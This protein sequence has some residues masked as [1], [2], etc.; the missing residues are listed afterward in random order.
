[1]STSTLYGISLVLHLVVCVAI[2]ATAFW[3]RRRYKYRFLLLFAFA[4]L[5]DIFIALA[6]LAALRNPLF[7]SEYAAL[8]RALQV[9]FI[10]SSL[11]FGTGLALL[12]RHIRAV[13]LPQRPS[14]ADTV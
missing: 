12:I 11:I 4:A 2:A 5:L 3:L 9:L 10:I 13:G 7:D 14:S 6:E 1:M 8:T